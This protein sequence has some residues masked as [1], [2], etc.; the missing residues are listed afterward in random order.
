MKLYY[1]PRT[2]AF[3]SLWMLEECGAEYDLGRID[4]RSPNHPSPEFLK[5]NPLGKLAALEDGGLGFGETAAILLYLADKFPAKKLAPSPTD[6][7][8]GRFLQWLIY[9]PSVIEPAMT[10]KATNQPVNT[11]AFG[12]GDYD[13]AMKALEDHL[14]TDGWI[15][16]PDFSAADLYI[17]STLSFG[18]MFKMIDARP[19]FA[20]FAD[21]A[22][23]RPSWAAAQAIDT[24]EAAIFDADTVKWANS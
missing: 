5:V 12:F 22:K 16:G 20:A 17:A 23:A 3:T 9:S 18:M 2:R 19:A 4:I 1:C 13:R 21:R 6:P 11:K 24:R 7:R 8:R 10:A 14:P 15:L